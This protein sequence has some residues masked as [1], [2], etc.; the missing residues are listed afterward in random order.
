MKALKEY[1][2]LLGL[3]VWDSFK[4]FFSE[5][6]IATHQHLAH[7]Y[8][9]FLSCLV[10]LRLAF[11]SLRLNW[12]CAVRRRIFVFVIV[13]LSHRHLPWL[14]LPLSIFLVFSLTPLCPA[15]MFWS[16]HIVIGHK[17]VSLRTFCC[18]RSHLWQASPGLTLPNVLLWRAPCSA[19]SHFCPD[20]THFRN[21]ILFPNFLSSL[22]SACSYW[23]LLP[24]GPVSSIS[25]FPFFFAAFANLI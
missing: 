21:F 2:K 13:P 25:L 5:G 20:I 4:S 10:C 12:L 15:L 9:N 22:C 1:S 16:W 19:S 17:M 11:Q 7:I 14:A 24:F 18:S 6:P 3:I 8:Q 23:H